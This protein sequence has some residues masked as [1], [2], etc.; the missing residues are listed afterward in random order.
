MSQLIPEEVV[1]T[2][3]YHVRGQKVMLDRDLAR[4]YGVTTGNLNK[5]VKRNQN[6]FPDDFMFQ[7]T[8]AEWES[9]RFQFGSLKRGQHPKYLP[10][11]F[12]QEGIA[13]L[14]GVLNSPQAIQVNITIMRVFAK[15]REI[16]MTHKD[17]VVASLLL[18]LRLWRSKRPPSL[19]SFAGRSMGMTRRL[20]LFWMPCGDCRMIRLNLREELDFIRS[21][22]SENECQN[23]RTLCFV[24]TYE[25]ILRRTE[26]CHHF[27]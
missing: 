12:T 8:A 25:I 4:L 5:A 26:F 18:L 21:K 13:M 16:M 11:A 20:K 6:R 14:S 15:L 7:L 19:R 24:I 27:L 23:C 17:L 3:V 2:K 22:T 10:Y 1:L 9:L